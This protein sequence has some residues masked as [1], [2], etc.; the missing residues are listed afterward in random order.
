[1]I[2]CYLSIS[3]CNKC[4]IFFVFYREPGQNV[5]CHKFGRPCIVGIRKFLGSTGNCGE[6]QNLPKNYWYLY[7][8]GTDTK[9]T[10][11]VA[12]KCRKCHKNNEF[13]TVVPALVERLFLNAL[14]HYR[15]GC[16]FPA[17]WYQWM[18]NKVINLHYTA[19]KKVIWPMWDKC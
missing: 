3:C 12:A 13:H 18:V 6:A 4:S 2:W 17:D 11:T 5:R 9:E 15:F 10:V 8:L 16:F 7:W 1:M 14:R 19:G